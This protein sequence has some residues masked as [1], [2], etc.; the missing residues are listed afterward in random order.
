M[1]AVVSALSEQ[2]LLAALCVLALLLQTGCFLVGSGM[3][4]GSACFWGTDACGCL[5][6]VGIAGAFEAGPCVGGASFEERM[7]FRCGSVVGI[8]VN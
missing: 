7:L 3:L 8:A 5:V 2:L 6:C 1:D 4:L